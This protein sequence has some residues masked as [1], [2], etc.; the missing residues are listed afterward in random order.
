VPRNP[1]GKILKAKMREKYTGVKESF[2][3]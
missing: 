3:I 1:T 2:K